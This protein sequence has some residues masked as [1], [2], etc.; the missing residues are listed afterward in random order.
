MRQCSLSSDR[1]VSCP[2]LRPKGWNR[3]GPG[4]VLLTV[5]FSLPWMVVVPEKAFAEVR[6]GLFGNPWGPVSPS[7]KSLGE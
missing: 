1:G 4:G 6:T 5:L 3:T 2:R 7:P